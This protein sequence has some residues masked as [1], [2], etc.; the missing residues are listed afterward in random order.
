MAKQ[1]VRILS[2]LGPIGYLPASGTIASLVTL[3]AVLVLSTQSIW[4]YGAITL[5]V[6]II[7]FYICSYA[8]PTLN[9]Q[10][11]REIVIDELVGC[12]VTFIGLPLSITDLV[13]GFVFFRIFDIFKIVGIARLERLPRAWGILLDDVAA[14][15]LANIMVRLISW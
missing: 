1:I 15:V 9:T 3:P 12:L 10:D 7:A 8:L 4:L 2:T 5:L 14:G 13:L 6:A 11:P